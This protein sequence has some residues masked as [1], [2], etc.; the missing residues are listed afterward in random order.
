M[1]KIKCPHCGY[2]QEP[3]RHVVLCEKCYAN[4][5]EVIEDHFKA[6]A[7]E[8]PSNDLRGSFLKWGW[9]ASNKQSGGDRRRLSGP[10]VIFKRTFETS[11]RRFLTLYPLIFFS[12]LFF[13]LT[14]VFTSR[15]GADIVSKMSEHAGPPDN[16]Y[17]LNMSIAGIIACLFIFFYGQAAFVFAVSNEEFG[18]RAALA[19]AWRRFSSYIALILVMAVAIGAGFM[20]FLIPAVIAGVFLA[21]TPFVFA[22]EDEGLIRSFSKSIRYVSSSWLQIFFR[23]APVSVA[24]IFVTYFFAYGGTGLLGTTQSVHASVFI[25]S[26]LISLPILF[27]AVF[28]FK[29]YEDVRT[30][31][32][33]ETPAEIT[34]PSSPQEVRTAPVSAG[35]SSFEE[36]LR[37]SWELYKRRFIPLSILNLIS[38]LPHG[39]HILI[40]LAGYFGFKIFFEAFDIKGDY[41]LLALLVLP[42]EILALF[43]VG[44]LLYLFLYVI[45]AVSGLMLYLHLELACVYAVADETIGVWEAIRKARKRFGG[46]FWTDLYRNFVVSTGGALFVP[47]VI[48][49]VWYEFTPYVFAL[50]REEQTPLTSLLK[51]REYVRG[52]WSP[53]F[54][55]LMSL[56]FLPLVIAS[57]FFFFVFAGLPFYWI[58][59]LFLSFFTGFHLPGML[60]VYSGFFW[61]VLFLLFLIMAGGFYLPFQKVFLYL[62]YRE[63]KDL[64]ADDSSVS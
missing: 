53:V 8:A 47:G 40:L 9:N 39:I 2:W 54:N 63:L 46:Y 49:W 10:L 16:F 30:V 60:T 7:E 21:F 15:I 45:S 58:F 38:C 51:S 55:Q 27:L 3:Y 28:I 57:I 61:V 31:E 64:K 48:F 56:R 41:G 62:L 29:I 14:G 35:L 11:I 1:A 36:L 20:L 6:K 33:F 13:M 17:S 37:R 4:I 23:L 42:G 5:K 25:I 22:A 59:G 44:A 32:G 34:A 52:L 43:I 19:K 50:E 26:A 18:T 12:F 24:V